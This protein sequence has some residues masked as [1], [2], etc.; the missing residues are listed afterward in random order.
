MVNFF[1]RRFM[2]SITAHI[3]AEP[4]LGT[5]GNAETV[6]NLVQVGVF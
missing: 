6:I 2:S 1:I 3:F 4:E 5:Q